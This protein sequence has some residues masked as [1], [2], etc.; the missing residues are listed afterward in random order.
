MLTITLRKDI[1]PLIFSYNRK[2]SYQ[3]FQFSSIGSSGANKNNKQFLNVVFKSLSFRGKP[4]KKENT[5]NDPDWYETYE[6]RVFQ[7][8]RTNLVMANN[9][10]SR[11]SFALKNFIMYPIILLS[12]YKFLIAIS[13]LRIF[14]TIFWGACGA[15]CTKIVR[16]L[17]VNR[18]Y[19]VLQIDLMDDGKNVVVKTEKNTK[20]YNI[21]D[22]RRLNNDE[23][24]MIS[25]RVPEFHLK[26]LPII[27]NDEVFLIDKT[28]NFS[29]THLFKEIC[30][31][32]FIKF[33]ET[34]NK[35]NSIDL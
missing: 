13:G 1:G 34:I 3:M 32:K 26:Y 16:G 27:I 30:N 4:D 31:G 8:S 12:T 20:T 5:N 15:I 21:K 29:D 33:K 22:I 24:I 2:K 9:Y 17:E 10:D 25:S 28:S 7:N 11:A 18:R 35:D 14:S 23:I 6:P 19:I